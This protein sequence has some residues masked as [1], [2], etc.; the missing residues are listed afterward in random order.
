MPIF[1][2]IRAPRASRKIV[3]FLFAFAIALASA[4]TASAQELTGVITGRVTSPQGSPISGAAVVAID[5]DRND[6]FSIQSD[7]KGIYHLTGLPIGRY[8][9]I[10]S[11]HGYHTSRHRSFT[12][13]FHQIARINVAMGTTCEVC[14]SD[15]EEPLLQTDSSEMRITVDGGVLATLPRP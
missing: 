10:T 9:V 7:G 2:S 3:L 4:A 1:Q 5:V 13:S 14:G 11:M 12:L 6:T 15:F 8:E